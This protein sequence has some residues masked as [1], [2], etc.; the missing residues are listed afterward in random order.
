MPGSC[1]CASSSAI[2]EGIFRASKRVLARV[3]C[4]AQFGQLAEK[5]FHGKG[6]RGIAFKKSVTGLGREGEEEV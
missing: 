5:L 4:G 6:G 2:W 1:V 3:H